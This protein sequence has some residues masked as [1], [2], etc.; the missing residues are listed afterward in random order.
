[1]SWDKRGKR[2]AGDHIYGKYGH[3]GCPVII[4]SS[5]DGGFF[6]RCLEPVPP[7]A[8][9]R[10]YCRACYYIADTTFLL[11]RDADYVNTCSL[12]LDQSYIHGSIN[13]KDC[14]DMRMDYGSVV[15]P[16]SPTLRFKAIIIHKHDPVWTILYLDPGAIF[17]IQI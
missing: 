1:M 2:L 15:L 13:N 6:A 5:I 8:R 7:V 3:T 14:F 9:I 17:A 10:R 4:A 11:V 12:P 16:R